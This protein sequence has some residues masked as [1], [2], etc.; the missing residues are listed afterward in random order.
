MTGAREAGATLA[1]WYRDSV[2]RALL[3]LPDHGLL[4]TDEASVWRLQQAGQAPRP[5]GAGLLQRGGAE[6]RVQSGAEERPVCGHQPG[7]GDQV[8]SADCGI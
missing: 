4:S 7:E 5:G 3:S 8:M 2:L 1:D 6:G